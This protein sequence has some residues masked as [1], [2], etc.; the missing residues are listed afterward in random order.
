MADQR[1]D[2]QSNDTKV[3]ESQ[4]LTGGS[5]SRGRINASLR[6][7]RHS[8]DARFK[9]SLDTDDK[10]LSSRFWSTIIRHLRCWL[11]LAVIALFALGILAGA[12]GGQLR[13]LLDALLR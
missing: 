4:R 13:E 5:E 9:A 7:N 8:F 11:A 1:P 12:I 10:E 6:I 3:G 2:G